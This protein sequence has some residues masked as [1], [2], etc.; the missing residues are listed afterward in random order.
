MWNSSSINEGL[1]VMSLLILRCVNREDH[2]LIQNP[3]GPAAGLH[4]LLMH[5]EYT[6]HPRATGGFSF[7]FQTIRPSPSPGRGS[8]P[9]QRVNPDTLLGFGGKTEA[10][11]GLLTASWGGAPEQPLPHP[12]T[13][14]SG[15]GVRR[16]ETWAHSC[17][18]HSPD[19]LILNVERMLLMLPPH[20]IV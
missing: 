14:G 9:A 11:S 5:W 3:R 20:K 2:R 15:R 18:A 8:D 12:P 17:L 19:A 4:A 16:P 1:D 13:R 10:E 6:A 7:F